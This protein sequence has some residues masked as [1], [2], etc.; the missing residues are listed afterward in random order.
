MHRLMIDSLIRLTHFWPV[1]F[2]HP[3]RPTQALMVYLSAAPGWRHSIAKVNQSAYQLV[4]RIAALSGA[5][6]R[7]CFMLAFPAMLDKVSTLSRQQ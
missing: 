7:R 4:G 5:F 2:I 3:D 6:S 1:T